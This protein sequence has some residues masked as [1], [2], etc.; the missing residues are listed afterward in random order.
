LYESFDTDRDGKSE[1]STESDL[2]D[3]EKSSSEED[4]D[5]SGGE[6]GE[7]SEYWMKDTPS[8]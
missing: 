2:S 1:S 6:L 3:W 4:L 5:E 7:E 8:P